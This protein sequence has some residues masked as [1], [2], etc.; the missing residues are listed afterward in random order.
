MNY[1][2]YFRNAEG[3]YTMKLIM[4]QFDTI[5]FESTQRVGTYML[6]DTGRYIFRL[7]FSGYKHSMNKFFAALY[8][9]FVNIS[10]NCDTNERMVKL[11]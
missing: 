7:E 3:L 2:T 1:R 5:K 9:V 4:S 11:E 10:I 6:F 8:F